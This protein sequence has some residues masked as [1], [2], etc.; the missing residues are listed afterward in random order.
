MKQ[1]SL[2]PKLQ[3]QDPPKAKQEVQD[4]LISKQ[5]TPVRNTVEIEEEELRLKQEEEKLNFMKAEFDKLHKAQMKE[6]QKRRDELEREKFVV[7]FS[8]SDSEDE[9]SVEEEDE[10][11]PIKFQWQG[12]DYW[13]T[14]DNYVMEEEDGAMVGRWD[15]ETETIVF[16]S[17]KEDPQARRS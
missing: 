12:K 10:D 6:I 1:A 13:R 5:A 8:M 2:S 14:W 4:T 15:P 7:D 17:D 3:L 9:S 16:L 11:K